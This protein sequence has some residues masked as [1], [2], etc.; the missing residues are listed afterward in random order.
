MPGGCSIPGLNLVCDAVGNTAKDWLQ[1]IADEAGSATAKVVQLVTS[2]WLKVATPGVDPASGSGVDASNAANGATTTALWLHDH[3]LWLSTWVSVLCLVLAGGRLAW[4]MRGLGDLK[5]ILHGLVTLVVVN[6]CVVAGTFA[7][8]QVGDTYSNWIIDQSLAGDGGRNMGDVVAAIAGMSS[9]L[10]MAFGGPIVAFILLGLA[11]LASLLNLVMGFFRAGVLVVLSGTASVPASSAVTDMGRRWL[12]RW[13]NWLLAFI[14]LKP[15]AATLYAAAY[16]LTGSGVGRDTISSIA[17]LALLAGTV[18]VLP[19]LLRLFQPAGMALAGGSVFGGEASR[20]STGSAPSGS[21][22]P[23]GARASAA[24]SG[25]SA[26]RAGGPSGAGS[27]RAG[28]SSSQPSGLGGPRSGG[29]SPGS[30]MAGG[31]G[32]SGG[33]AGGGAAGGS[34]GG[35]RGAAGGGAGQVAGA[36]QA[37]VDAAK[38][39]T[40]DALVD[41]T[42]GVDRELGDG[43][44]GS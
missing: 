11:L 20:T 19:A 43:P 25:S 37:K 36:V 35:A 27:S 44:S 23:S 26:G 32:R 8:T 39:R 12:G 14:V 31:A 9:E 42:R 33:G 4:N 34:G 40:R 30:Q 13:L 5:V 6:G 2:G 29:Q 28:L 18:V 24:G 16:V 7:L 41:S 1:S 38:Q 17:G 21:A 15:A 3:T 22:A 10:S